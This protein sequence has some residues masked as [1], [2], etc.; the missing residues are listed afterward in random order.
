MASYRLIRKEREKLYWKLKKGRSQNY[1][2][3]KIIMLPVV[4]LGQ[5]SAG[6][7]IQAISLGFQLPKLLL[8]QFCKDDRDE[9]GS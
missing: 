1:F 8:S 9:I 7:L 3:S 2:F 4:K 5:F 6:L